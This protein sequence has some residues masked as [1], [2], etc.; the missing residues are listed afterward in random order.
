MLGLMLAHVGGVGV[1]VVFMLDLLL[2]SM[3]VGDPYACGPHTGSVGVDVGNNICVS[4][5][6]AVGVEVVAV[7]LGRTD[8][9]SS[10][11]V[12]LAWCW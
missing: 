11:W 8:C 4:V 5:G 2:V 3:A 7:A 9:R 1:V 6:S 12:V 10:A